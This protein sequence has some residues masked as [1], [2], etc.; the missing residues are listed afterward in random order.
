VLSSRQVVTISGGFAGFD[1]AMAV[2]YY[3]L[4]LIGQLIGRAY[5]KLVGGYTSGGSLTCA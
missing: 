3:G 4:V 1:W 2:T 5:P